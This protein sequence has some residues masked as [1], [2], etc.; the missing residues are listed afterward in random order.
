VR[1]AEPQFEGQTKEVLGTPAV[2]GIVRSV[3]SAELKR[4]L[5]ST[6]GRE[7]AQAKVVLEKVVSA[8][9]TRIAA[10][11]HRETQR[12]KNA[13]ESSALPAKLADC[14]ST[15]TERSE[16]FIVEGDSALGTA[17]LARDSEFQALLP[18]RGKILNVQKASVGDMLK[19]SECASI[20]QV[21]GAGSGRTFDIDG[22]RY[23]R[24]IFMAD[25]DSDGAHIRCLLATLFFKYMPDL[26]AQGRVF[27]AVPP[28]HRIEL[29][30]PKKG[31]DKYAYTYSDPELQRKLAELTKK[32]VRWK[33]PVQ[34]YKGL[35]EMDA[36]QL[37]ETTM[38]PRRRTLRRITVDDADDAARVFELLMGSDVAP[39]KDFI[40]QGAYEVDAE[41]IDA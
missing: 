19:N 34:R 3:V 20:I 30:N 27:S 2:R 4:F 37:S 26:L 12:R 22:V 5:T 21:V 28:L 8:S 38:D 23:G 13:L 36:K 41:A 25:A 33:D 31:M 1:L 18:I 29:S 14:R 15:D 24:I 35:G 10:R 32:G 11:Q 40:V 6:R 16:L 39:R 7:R 9:R 17:K